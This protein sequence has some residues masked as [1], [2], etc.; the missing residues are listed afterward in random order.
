MLVA[1]LLGAFL[2]VAPAAA[3]SAQ[4]RA[5]LGRIFERGRLIFALDRAAWVATDDLMARVPDPAAAGMRGY[6]AE[7]DGS[8]LA[9]IFYGGPRE[10]PVAFYRARVENNRVVSSQVYPEPARPSLTPVQRRMSAVR[11]MAG[12]LGLSSCE[13]TFNTVIIPPEAPDAPIDMYLLTPQLR[14]DEWPAG[15]HYRV[16][17]DPDGRVAGSRA[18]TNSCINLSGAPGVA[19][20]VM[21]HLLDPLPTEIHVFTALTSGLPLFVGT[22]ETRRTWEVDRDGIRLVENLPQRGG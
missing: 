20:L 9:V 21:T 2:G 1:A 12:N 18:F 16:T 15:G 11:A 14:R 17:F 10:A 13:G 7:R 6:I 4:E 19:G 8:G 5:Q 3:Q 22:V